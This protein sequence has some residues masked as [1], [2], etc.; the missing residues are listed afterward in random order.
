MFSLINEGVK[1]KVEAEEI[2]DLDVAA[3]DGVAGGASIPVGTGG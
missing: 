1:D 2:N 3:L